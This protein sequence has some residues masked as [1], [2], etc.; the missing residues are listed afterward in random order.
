MPN[1][2]TAEGALFAM[3]AIIN[4]MTT[5]KAMLVTDGYTPAATHG[6]ADAAAH[7]C[8]GTT[9]VTIALAAEDDAANS[10]IELDV[11][12]GGGVITFG[13]VTAGQNAKWLVIYDDAATDTALAVLEPLPMIAANG[14]D[15]EITLS[16]TDGSLTMTYA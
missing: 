12:T 4:A 14:G 10:R 2:W 1:F 3:N 8:A 13:S 5:P 7:R 15:I 9:D 16:Q 11:T 6:V